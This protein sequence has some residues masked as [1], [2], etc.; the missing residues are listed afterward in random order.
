[1]SQTMDS[2]DQ[3]LSRDRQTSS[4]VPS[5][6]LSHHHI[7]PSIHP[8]ANLSLTAAGMIGQVSTS[9]TTSHHNQRT[10]PPRYQDFN[11]STYRS[12]L[13]NLKF[14]R[15]ASPSR[16]PFQHGGFIPQ[17]SSAHHPPATHYHHNHYHHHQQSLNTGSTTGLEGSGCRLIEYRGAQVIVLNCFCNL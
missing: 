9:L 11:H 7:H 1:M 17:S 13:E 15:L 8:T 3:I 10:S 4:Q 14:S 5:S 16:P 2:A 6:L 12:A